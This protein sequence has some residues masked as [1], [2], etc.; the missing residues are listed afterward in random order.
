MPEFM[1][2]SYLRHTQTKP[3]SSTLHRIGIMHKPCPVPSKSHQ[4]H[5]KIT[6][7][8]ICFLYKSH[9]H[10]LGLT[11]EPYPNHIR[12]KAESYQIPAQI[13]Q[14]QTGLRVI[15]ADLFPNISSHT[16]RYRSPDT[17]PPLPVFLWRSRCRP[18]LRLPVPCQ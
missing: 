8:H 3:K 7:G 14:D 17:R 6:T 12:I 4:G 9:L 1:F 15:P 10:H 11:S 2:G 18:D 5:I 16:S 13:N